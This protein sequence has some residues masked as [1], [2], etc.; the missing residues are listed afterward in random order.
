MATA[1]EFGE[2]VKKLKHQY[3]KKFDVIAK[4]YIE[5]IKEKIREAVR[6]HQKHAEVNLPI[7]FDYEGIDNKTMQVAIYGRIL[8]YLRFAN[9][10]N[11]K[12][13][14]AKGMTVLKV[15]V[16]EAKELD[17]F[18][19]YSKLVQSSIGGQEKN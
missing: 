1:K 18:S 11:C 7:N 8:A 16:F 15:E 12:L 14:S 9:F 4:P 19:V 3:E 13:F 10:A 6:C 2:E 5:E 17:N